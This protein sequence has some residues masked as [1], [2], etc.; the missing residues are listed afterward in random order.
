MSS[1]DDV[2]SGMCIGSSHVRVSKAGVFWVTSFARGQLTDRVAQA[3]QTD[4]GTDSC[5]SKVSIKTG[6]APL[7]RTVRATVNICE[8]SHNVDNSAL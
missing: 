8:I 1:G 7:H 5:F 6:C 4:Y 2:F 3:Y